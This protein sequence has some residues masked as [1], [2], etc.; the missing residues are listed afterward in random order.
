MTSLCTRQRR[1][2]VSSR[3]WASSATSR[4]PA[5]SSGGE[6]G[7]PV[8]V[9]GDPLRQ[10]L[11]TGELRDGEVPVHEGAGARHRHP[12]QVREQ[13]PEVVAEGGEP[14]GVEVTDDLVAATARQVRRHQQRG[15]AGG[16]VGVAH[17]EHL[18]HRQQPAHQAEQRGVHLVRPVAPVAGLG[19]DPD[20]GALAAGLGDEGLA[21]PPSREGHERGEVHPSSLLP[22]SRS[23]RS[24]PCG[25]NGGPS[26]SPSHAGPTAPTG[27]ATPTS[28]KPPT[29]SSSATSGSCGAPRA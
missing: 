24:G 9:R 23:G 13:H 14:A 3:S 25:S 4:S 5:S 11:G 6:G 10:S 26:T 21:R 1:S 16:G 29:A 7:Q 22:C 8:L 18:G 19:V 12:A 20:H 2:T 17:L 28:T 15:R 27:T